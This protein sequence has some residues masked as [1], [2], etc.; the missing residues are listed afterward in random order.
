MFKTKVGSRYQVISYDDALT[1]M[2][3]DAEEE[4]DEAEKGL[5]K[6]QED[7]EKL[8]AIKTTPV[9]KLE[10]LEKTVEQLEEERDDAEEKLDKTRHTTIEDLKA[11]KRYDD[12]KGSR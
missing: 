8:I 2:V 11:D 12:W 9:E 10:A 4:L 7:Y 5:K 1:K 3:E 6:A